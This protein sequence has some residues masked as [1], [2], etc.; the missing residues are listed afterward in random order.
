MAVP[1]GVE[2]MVAPLRHVLVQRPHAAFGAAFD[3]PANGYLHA[4][5]LDAARAEHDAFCDLLASLGVAVHHL[6]ADLAYPDQVY[7]Y[8]PAIVTR[9]GAILLRSGKK[10]R[11]GEEDVMGE[12]LRGAEIPIVGRV[13]PPGTVDGGDVLWLRPGLVA[14]GRSLRTSQAGIDQL[15]A[16]LDEQVAVFDLPFGAGPESCL[17]LMSTVSLVSHDLAVVDAPR[18][19]V[20]LFALLQDFGVK[21]LEVPSEEVATLGG[22]VLAVR[23]RV[24]VGVAGNPQTH[25]LLESAGIEVHPF[26]GEEIAVNG[27]G[28]PTCL[29]RPLQRS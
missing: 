12:W 18:L 6:D 28:G 21:M 26:A 13:E 5:D 17:H 4:V 2:S 3:D 24:V 15:T 7:T 19:P 11:R 25:Q 29:T 20:G 1:Y 16:L 27:T 14:V 23:P 9:H 22:N 8:D 10:A